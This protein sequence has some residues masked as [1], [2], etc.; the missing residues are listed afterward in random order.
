[1]SNQVKEKKKEPGMFKLVLVLALISFVMA[2]LLGMVNNMTAPAIA[3]NTW[4]KTEEAMKQVLPADSYTK[5]EY[6]GSNALVNDVYQAGDAGYVVLVTPTS[7]FS[8]AIEMMAGF[9]NDGAV[10]GIAIINH[11][12]TSGLGSKATDPKWQAQFI[13]AT[14][15]V[16]VQKDG[17]TIVAITGS[18]ITSRAICDGV[19]AARS[20]LAELG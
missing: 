6:S 15:E 8:G 12:E 17:G 7:G 13:E 4:A 19:N 14:D 18:T 11:A 10:T 16:K 5:I 20:A 9:S 2:F 3:E 1:M